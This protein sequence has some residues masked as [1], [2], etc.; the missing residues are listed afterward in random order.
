[1][2]HLKLNLNAWQRFALYFLLAL[3]LAWMHGLH[4]NLNSN[5]PFV[6]QEF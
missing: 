2:A 6:Y 3:G 1:M 4:P 5:A